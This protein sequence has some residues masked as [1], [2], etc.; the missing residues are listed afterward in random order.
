MR[1]SPGA[2]EGVAVAGTVQIAGVRF[3][4]VTGFPDLPALTKPVP[5]DPT[6]MGWMETPTS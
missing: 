6:A 3:V 5:L 1:E 4:N 2:D